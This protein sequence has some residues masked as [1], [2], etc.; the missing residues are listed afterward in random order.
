VI[1]LTWRQHRAA[2]AFTLIFG[3]LAVYYVIDGFRLHD[4]Y[5]SSGLAACVGVTNDANCAGRR[6]EFL[7]ITVGWLQYA[8]PFIAIGSGAL[9]V[10]LGAPLIAG[11]IE[12]GTHQW[13]WTQ[14][15]SRTRWLA[16]KYLLLAA[17][18]GL[19][20]ATLGAAYT[21]WGRPVEAL[22][23]PFGRFGAFDDTPLLLAAYSVFAFAASVT[24][25]VFLRRTVPAMGITAAVFIIARVGVGYGLRPRYRT[26]VFVSSAPSEAGIPLGFDP[27]DWDWHSTWVDAGGHTVSEST[28]AHLTNPTFNP[29][30]TGLDAA[31]VLAHHGIHY[32]DA[33]QPCTRAGAFQL[34]EFGIYALLIGTCAVAAFV[35]MTCGDRF[36]VGTILFALFT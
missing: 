16:T 29:A 17:V 15:I 25:S 27:R 26:P 31:T 24:A 4:A 22:T 33:V 1:W 23:G 34:I 5:A 19:L 6:A 32:V 28:V 13:A 35:P 20:A 7:A 10:F 3:G 9:G 2:A 18:V 11:E 8:G 12:R 14:R 36:I 21:W 30:A